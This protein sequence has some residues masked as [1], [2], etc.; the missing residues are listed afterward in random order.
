MCYTDAL[1]YL[2]IFVS[3]VCERA[4]VCLFVVCVQPKVYVNFDFQPRSAEELEISR[5]EVITVIN[6]DD[7]D[8]WEGQIERDGVLH[9]GFFPVNYVTSI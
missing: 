6:T 5:G 7:A 2:L 3:K 8:W 9:C 1:T 4:S